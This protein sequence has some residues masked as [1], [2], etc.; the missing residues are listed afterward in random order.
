MRPL[1]GIRVVDLSRVLA[2]PYCSLLLAD[3]GAEV[4]K[5]EE[6]GRGDDTRA[7]PPFVGGEA[8]YFMSVNRG[9]KSLTLNMKHAEG[10]GILRRLLEGADVLL[11]NFRPGT[12][13][14]LGFG[15][16]AVRSLNPRL[17]YC[18]ISG[19]GESGPEAGRP[20][21]D[22]IV[23][24]ESGIMDITGFPDGP[25]VKVGNSIA[26]L[27]AGTMAA[28]GIVLA[29]FA[30]ERTG[31]GQKV[32]IAML[33]VMAALLTYHGQAYFATGKSPRR[34]GNQH[35]SIVPYEVFQ[36]ADGYLTVG[37]ANNSL[38]SR[39]CQAIG[40]PDLTADPRFDTEARRVEN[41]DALVPLLV[42]VF[43]T[44]PVAH[45]LA[46]L[47]EAGVPAG[48]I[49]EIGEVLE[50]EHL[51]ARG[52]VVSLTHPTAGPMRM[53]GPP[54]R[55]SGTP[56]EAAAPAPLLGEH[57]E[58]ILGKLCGYSAD[59]IARLRADGAV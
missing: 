29:L 52:A 55:L 28:H 15:Y 8:T 44:A 37:V 12:L 36:A 6:P 34:R 49:K 50:S 27:A 18:S 58:E 21:Y 38:W 20:G 19:F 11:E 39:F 54:I 2:G 26:D 45:W 4:V 24:G 47:G 30:R 48:K 59:A 3:M 32:E 1:D 7:W 14:R 9:K 51:R 42:A 31:Q 22:L 25:P 56:A 16:A 10:K 13:E 5:V 43:A 23:Q 17:V 40:R 46:R 35:P 41:R 33:E 53:V 57:T